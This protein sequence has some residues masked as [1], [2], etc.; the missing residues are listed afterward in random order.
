M[1]T[2]W[3]KSKTKD[4]NN[5]YS[6]GMLIKVKMNVLVCQLLLASRFITHI[7]VP[8]HKSKTWLQTE[9][10]HKA[11]CWF[12][13]PFS[14]PKCCCHQVVAPTSIWRFGLGGCRMFRYEGHFPTE[15]KAYFFVKYS[16]ARCCAHTSTSINI[17]LNQDR[18]KAPIKDTWNR[19]DLLQKC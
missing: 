18:S 17:L 1:F 19:T 11:L 3:A 2:V 6:T 5:H 9:A 7:F 15:K 12:L 16:W 13:E 10:S 14:Q 8:Q 4:W